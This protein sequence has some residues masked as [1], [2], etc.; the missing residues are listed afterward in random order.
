MDLKELFTDDDAVS[1]VIGVILMVAITVILAAVI[2][3]FVLDIGG[4]QESAPQVQWDWSDNSTNTFDGNAGTVTTS[5]GGGDTVNS[6]SQI[7][8]DADNMVPSAFTLDNNASSWTAGQSASFEVS[9]DTG[10]A[11]LTWQSSDGSQST[12]LSTH[13]YDVSG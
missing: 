1:P 7:T 6:P 3:A 11:T 4:S 13:E 9:S 12:E 10:T 8:L 5:H 2:G